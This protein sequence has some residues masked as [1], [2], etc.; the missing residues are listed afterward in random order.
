MFYVGDAL[1][2]GRCRPILI[3][4]RLC[5]MRQFIKDLLYSVAVA[6]GMLAFARI[7][8]LSATVRSFYLSIDRLTSNVTFIG[9]FDSLMQFILAPIQE[10]H[11]LIPVFLKDV[12]VLGVSVGT[13]VLILSSPPFIWTV[14]AYF[15]ISTR[16]RLN[17]AISADPTQPC[18][19]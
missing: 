1:P 18:R 11:H 13:L 15:L 14:V 7:S 16:R 2:S 10:P 3:N 12:P 17:A 6:F 8:L 4:S 19:H 9:A 5:G